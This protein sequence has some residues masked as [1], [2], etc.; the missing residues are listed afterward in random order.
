M[1]LD[2]HLAIDMYR[3]N[4][5]LLHMLARFKIHHI[6]NFACHSTIARQCTVRFWA[7]PLLWHSSW[8]INFCKRNAVQVCMGLQVPCRVLS[9]DVLSTRNAAS[10]LIKC[11]VAYTSVL[12]QEFDLKC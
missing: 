12:K 5:M 9:S 3:C 10:L 7:Q 8:K 2:S 1:Q 11:L 4:R 6:P